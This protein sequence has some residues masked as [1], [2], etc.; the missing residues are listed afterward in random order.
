[1]VSVGKDVYGN[2]Q[3]DRW[4]GENWS[5]VAGYSTSPIILSSMYLDGQLLL[6]LDTVN[7]SPYS[8][9]LISYIGFDGDGD[10]IPSGID[11]CEEVPNPS[12]AD[13]DFD[14]VG[15]ACDNCPS[16]ANASQSDFD[17]DGVG[18]ACDKCPSGNDCQDCDH[19]G[20]PDECDA[21]T[22]TYLWIPCT[23]FCDGSDC[24]GTSW[25]L[26]GRAVVGSGS[27]YYVNRGY[28]PEDSCSCGGNWFT[29]G[30]SSDD[31]CLPCSFA[32]YFWIVTSTC[33]MA[34]HGRLMADS[35][36]VSVHLQV[37]APEYISGIWQGKSI[38][39]WLLEHPSVRLSLPIP[40]YFTSPVE[41]VFVFV[42]LNQWAADPLP[43]QEEYIITN[44][45]C[46]DLPGYLI[47]TTPFTFD[48]LASSGVNPV[49]T[50]PFSGTLTLVGSTSA[51][52]S[53]YNCGDANGD[54]TVDISD[55]VYLIAYIFSGGSAP[56]PLLAGD[57]NCD[58]TVDISDVVY[59]IAYIFS[60]G[61]APC[62]AC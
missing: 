9:S 19:D 2:L 48:S 55:V 49:S 16:L 14:G 39:D 35:L 57:A 56:S 33:Q 6:G 52:S 10:G 30:H 22:G 32:E 36:P 54:A 58:D 17:W 40:G 11:N 42:D 15:D 21:C 3:I 23:H 20:I 44:G 61:A 4:D 46:P 5:V 43:N 7:L 47:G 25:E 1:M 24:F 62:A 34:P 31:A 13:A 41:T 12:Q 59:L 50:I 8:S 27:W 37:G 26:W 51:S 60:G 45:L 28:V 38:S 53:N 29:G 18:D